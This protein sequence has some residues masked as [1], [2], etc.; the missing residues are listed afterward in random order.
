MF[1]ELT[2]K[3]IFKLSPWECLYEKHFQG[4]YIRYLCFRAGLEISNHPLT[5]WR[6]NW[7]SVS[8]A[9]LV[10]VILYN[11]FLIVVFP[12][13]LQSYITN[14]RTSKHWTKHS[15]YI[16]KI[17]TLE[18]HNSVANLATWL[19]WLS[20]HFFSC[21]YQQ[22]QQHFGQTFPIDSCAQYFIMFCHCKDTVISQHHRHCCCNLCRLAYFFKICPRY[23]SVFKVRYVAM[24]CCVVV[25]YADV[26][27]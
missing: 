25:I 21:N 7:P 26:W 12:S 8:L 24:C 23:I 22:I 1:C 2:C 5:K 10:G 9:T 3:K 15:Y 11:T 27:L 17:T 19:F 20:C 14:T 13:T 18:T 6:S 16:N 4:I